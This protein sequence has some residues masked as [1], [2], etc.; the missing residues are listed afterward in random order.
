[1]E[2]VNYLL[3]DFDSDEFSTS[4]IERLMKIRYCAL[5]ETERKEIGNA[6]ASIESDLYDYISIGSPL[7]KVMSYLP[8]V[9]FDNSD[10]GVPT[11][12]TKIGKTIQNIRILQT[13]VD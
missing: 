1:M 10:D 5:S 8:G 9:Y 6:M 12:I 3:M 13:L 2:T 4:D 11:V 7:Y